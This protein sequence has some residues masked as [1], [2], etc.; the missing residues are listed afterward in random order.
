[1]TIKRNIK[2]EHSSE[3]WKVAGNSEILENKKIIVIDTIVDGEHNFIIKIPGHIDFTTKAALTRGAEHRKSSLRASTPEVLLRR[4]LKT[5][6]IPEDS[7][8]K[9]NLTEELEKIQNYINEEFIRVDKSYQ[10]ETRE[11]LRNMLAH[12]VGQMVLN[13]DYKELKVK[14]LDLLFEQFDTTFEEVK[15]AIRRDLDWQE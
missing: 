7:K 6:A 3:I 15:R 12:S 13:I 10:G 9:D 4:T 8:A 2:N 11:Y 14:T 5:M 1:M